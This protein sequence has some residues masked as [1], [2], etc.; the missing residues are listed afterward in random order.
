V[1]IVINLVRTR[2]T[3]NLLKDMA[4]LVRSMHIVLSGLHYICPSMVFPMVGLG[5]WYQSWSYISMSHELLVNVT[6]LLS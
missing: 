2:V 4:N 3:L 6:K 5:L 1:A